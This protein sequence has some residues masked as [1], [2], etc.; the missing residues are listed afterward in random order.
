MSKGP[1]YSVVM[2]VENGAADFSGYLLDLHGHLD[3]LGL[4]HELILAV[5][6]N[7]AFA[8][9]CLQSWPEGGPVVQVIELTPR[10]SS[11]CRR[12]PKAGRTWPCRGGR[13]GLTRW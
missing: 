2:L 11:G 12:C 6:G 7:G 4:S 8:R 3:R 13:D 10:V 5:N 9:A 1:D